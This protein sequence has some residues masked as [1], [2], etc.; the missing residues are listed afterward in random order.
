MRGKRVSL[1]QEKEIRALIGTFNLDPN[2]V[3]SVVLDAYE[4]APHNKAY[5]GLLEGM[6][7]DTTVTQVLGAQF[8]VPLTDR[9]HP[10]R[11]LYAVCA[12][13]IKVRDLDFQRCYY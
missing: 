10:S 12:Y 6:F 4:Q 11:N 9:R 13:L 8:C 3:A 2:R 5:F 7:R 1:A